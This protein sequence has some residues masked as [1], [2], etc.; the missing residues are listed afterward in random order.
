MIEIVSLLRGGGVSL[1]D[2]L[3]V[4]LDVSVR[5]IYRDVASLQAQGFPIEGEAG[6]GYMMREPIDLPSLTFDHDEMEALTLGLAYVEQAG[7][8]ELAS[9][10][11]A[12]LW[13]I[14][15]AWSDR[16]LPGPSARS[17][18]AHQR[19]ERRAPPLAAKLRRAIRETRLVTFDYVDRHGEGTRRTVRPLA[20]TAYSDGW[21]FVAWCEMRRDFRTF[22]LDRITPP[23]IAGAVF[24]PEPGK[25]LD[26]YLA[27]QRLR[28]SGL[29]P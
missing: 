10:A 25:R 28:A 3:A 16:A 4:R 1:A 19:A 20:L 9:A 29:R 6:V 5:T 21:M 17:L 26:D 18:R 13:E 12:A 14:D 15:R 23:L 2:R 7:D 11:R 27:L 8:R 24:P 22:R